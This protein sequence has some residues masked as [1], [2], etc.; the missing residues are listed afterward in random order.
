[1]EL[2]SCFIL[3]LFTVGEKPKPGE[4]AK[5]TAHETPGTVQLDH[6]QPLHLPLPAV[7]GFTVYIRHVTGKRGD[8]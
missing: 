6:R 2:P 4:T 5:T 8:V 1:M 3:F 7:S